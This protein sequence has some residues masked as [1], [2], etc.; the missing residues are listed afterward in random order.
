MSLILLLDRPL[1]APPAAPPAIVYSLTVNGTPKKLQPGWT[2]NEAANWRNTF[3][4]EVLSQDGTYRPPIG[5]E[6][7]V[8]ENGVRI[9]GG[10]IETPSES[11]IGDRGFTGIT[12]RVA[13]SDFNGYA[14]RRQI[15]LDLPVGSLKALLQA[16]LP[17]LTAYGVTLDPGQ[18]TGP[19]LPAVS[20][21]ARTLKE[22]LD[23]AAL[24][25]SSV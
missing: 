12:T 16:L 4:C 13:A 2:I 19:T 6:V 18:V 3:N 1:V 11:G 9:F 15:D 7:V 14:D 17:F 5:A 22:I 8:T 21:R 10:L 23:D 24:L 25:A 20:Y